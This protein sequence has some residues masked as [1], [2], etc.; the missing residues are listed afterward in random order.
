MDGR[1][2]RTQLIDQKLPTTTPLLPLPSITIFYCVVVD[3]TYNK[4][5]KRKETRVKLA[6]V[7]GEIFSSGEGV[8]KATAATAVAKVPR[9][10]TGKKSEPSGKR[11]I[12]PSSV[13]K[14]TGTERENKGN[15]ER[16][17]EKVLSRCP[18]G[19]AGM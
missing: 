4:G 1:K 12:R 11:T 13:K 3:A 19:L 15:K 9:S 17:G 5:D 18:G 14:T 6:R 2:A 8:R 16:K 10:S 7:K